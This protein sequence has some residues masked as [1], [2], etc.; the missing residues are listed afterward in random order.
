MFDEKMKKI[1]QDLQIKIGAEKIF[2][3]ISYTNLDE[4]SFIV[5]LQCLDALMRLVSPS[6][7]HKAWSRYFQFNKFLGT[8][9]NRAFAVKDRRFGALPAS[10]LVALHHF[11][12]ILAYLDQNPDCRNQLACICRG[13][14]DLEEV[15]NDIVLLTSE[16]S[17]GIL[18]DSNPGSLGLI[19]IHLYEPYLYLIIDLNTV[20]SVLLTLFC[21][22]Y[23]ELSNP[24]KHGSLCQFQSPAFKSLETA[25]RSPSSPESPYEREVIES[26]ENYLKDADKILLQA[27]IDDALKIL[28]AGF[29][30]QKGSAYGFGPSANS[31]PTITQ[32]L[33]LQKLDKFHTHSKSI[34]NAFGHMDNLLRQTGA[35]GF[36]KAVQSMQIASAKDLVFD[37]WRKMPMQMRLRLKDMQLEWNASQQK[38]LD[39][40]VKD[41]DVSALQRAQMLTKL[42]ASLKKHDGPLNSDDD[43]NKFLKKYK[44]L[45]EKE[46]AKMLNEE[47]RFR[48]D[49]NLRYSVSKDCYLYRQHGITND[50]RIK[51]LR[52]LVQHPEARSSATIDDLRSVIL[53]EE[54]AMELDTPSVEKEPESVLPQV[55]VFI[56]I[57]ELVKNKIVII[58]FYIMLITFKYSGS[59][60]YKCKEYFRVG[61]KWT[62]ATNCW[63]A[64][65]HPV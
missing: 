37:S 31:E 50:Q 55:I 34:E 39:S 17:Q 41:S 45:P 11:D 28:A 14:A 48:R 23:D 56:H 52:L 1:W 10:C 30:D 12:D 7:S 47:I 35:Q 59:V 16:K 18:R 33:S 62:M 44:N 58:W 65:C 46:L 13:M 43:I 38:L 42:I 29:A 32:E 5:I 61:I 64:S 3:S 9:K 60:G 20:Q 22:L 19:G 63:R 26:L 15:L 57:S 4:N 6:Y 54:N 25:W 2:P 40:G 27:H 51:N 8:R 49:S 36:A 53:P 24:E 21:Q